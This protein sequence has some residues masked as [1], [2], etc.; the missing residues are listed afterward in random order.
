MSM[1]LTE[2]TELLPMRGVAGLNNTA[3]KGYVAYMMHGHRNTIASMSIME[4]DTCSHGEFVGK[5]V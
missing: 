2:M 3:R 5:H 4:E 1:C